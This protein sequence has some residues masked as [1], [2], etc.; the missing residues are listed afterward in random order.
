MPH[1]IEKAIRVARESK[2]CA[3]AIFTTCGFPRKNSAP[4]IARAAAESGADLIELGVPFSDPL[5]DGPAIQHSSQVGLANGI[6]VAVC[7]RQATESVKNLTVPHLL[8]TYLNPILAFGTE[9]FFDGAAHAGVK[10]VIVP[11][12]PPNH[13]APYAEQAR[14]AGVGLVPLV[15]SVSSDSALHEAT[16][17]GHGMIYCVGLKGTTGSA[18]VDDTATKDLVG[19]VKRLTDVPAAVGFG[20][21][22][23]RSF[24]SVARYADCAIVGSALIKKVGAD[25]VKNVNETTTEFVKSIVRNESGDE[26]SSRN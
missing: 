6:T 22:D 11:D 1:S 20:I 10:G 8:M 13:A 9:R 3:L 2:G 24:E 14:R 16:G 23:R 25:C 19:R 21:R 7:L 4:Q 12:L 17:Y 18:Q 26:N 15:S 5:A